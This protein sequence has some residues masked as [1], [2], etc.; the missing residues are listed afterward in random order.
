MN[1]RRH[2]QVQRVCGQGS[3]SF[4]CF[5]SFAGDLAEFL[6]YWSQLR[7]VVKLVIV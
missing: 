6:A 5:F 2:G 3:E 4:F 1:L 7:P